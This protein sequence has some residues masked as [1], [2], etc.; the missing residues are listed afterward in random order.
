MKLLLPVSSTD[1]IQLKKGDKTHFEGCVAHGP[2]GGTRGSSWIYKPKGFIK[3]ILIAHGDFVWGIKFYSVETESSQFGSNGGN[4]TNEIFINYPSEYLTSISGTFNCDGLV[5]IG[6]LCFRTNHSC[7]GPYGLNSKGTPFS[8]SEKG[9]MIVGFHGRIIGIHCLE[10]IGVYVMPESFASHLNSAFEDNVTHKLCSSMTMPRD[11]G[12]WGGFGGKPWDDGVYSTV[13][14]V[15]VHFRESLNVIYAIQ[16]EYVQRDAKSVLS[17]THGGT[18]GDTMELVDLDGTDEYLTGIS[19]FYGPVK[20]YNGV[21]A[22]TSITF[23]TNK[24]KHGPYGEESGAGY[25]CFSSTASC[26]KVVEIDVDF[27]VTEMP[28]KVYEVGKGVK[29]HIHPMILFPHFMQLQ[30][31]SSNFPPISSSSSSFTQKKHDFWWKAKSVCVLLF[32]YCLDSLGRQKDFEG[33]VTHGPWGGSQGNNWIYMPKSF[34]KKILIVHGDL[35]RGI[36]FYSVESESSLFGTTGGMT[37]CYMTEM[38]V[39]LQIFINYPHE[40][41]TSISGTFY[42]RDG[43]VVMGSLYFETNHSRYGPYGSDLKGT[44]FSYS[45][46]GVM[47][48]GFHGRTGVYRGMNILEAIGVYVMPESSALGLSSAFGDN[49]TPKLCSRMAVPRDAGPWGGSGGI[50]WDDGVFATVKRARLYFEGS[51]KVIYAVQFEYVQRDAKSVLSPMHGGTGGDKMELVDLNG[52]DE[53]LTGISGFYGPIVGYNG[54]EAIKSITFH[55]NKTTY[56]P[57]GRERGEGYSFFNSTASSGKVVGFHGRKWN[58]GYLTAIGVHMDMTMTEKLTRQETRQETEGRDSLTTISVGNDSYSRYPRPHWAQ[59]NPR[60]FWAEARLLKHAARGRS[61][62]TSRMRPPGYDFWWKAKS[63]YIFI[64]YPNEYLTSISGTFYSFGFVVVESLRFTTNHSRYGPYGS[65]LKGTPF[66]FSEKGAM[67]VG[68]HGSVYDNEFLEAIGVY[69]MPESS[70]LGLSSAFEDNSTHKVHPMLCSSLTMPRD[71]GPWGGFGGKTWDDGVFST[72]K[73]V[74]VHFRESLNVIY[75]IQFEYVRRDAKSVLSTTHGGTGGDTMELV[76]LDGTDEYLTGISGFYG[77]VKGYNG[78]EA[79]TS[80]TFHTNKRKHGPYGDESG[81]GY[82][83]FNS[84]TSGGKVVGFHGRNDG[85]LKA[86]GVHME[87]F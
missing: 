29:E 65:N 18:G 35:V 57:Y 82:V 24:G 48:V 23:H 79:I 26:G 69:V 38:V 53:Y 78:L 61:P 52:A 68:F 4:K 45:G 33:C 19:G 10:A 67:I 84:T 25:T 14:Q 5:T 30:V 54:G 46:K 77:P 59:T 6:S 81:A 2:W 36:K 37:E 86:I 55:T 15:S 50:P 22:I 43:T 51:L 70:A 39:I 62:R 12:P 34:I 16:F 49:S 3:K 40:Y 66:S 27:T 58:E 32:S 83:C 80:I 11:A 13:K 76:D 63:V 28:M 71:A 72:I 60:Q 74:R 73:Q 75:A 44:P 1:I 87:Y 31:P 85:F 17:P 41:L 64:N 56:G 42:N 47:I 9:A 7:Y 21:E 20:G 8:F